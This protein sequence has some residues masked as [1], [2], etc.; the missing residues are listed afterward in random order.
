MRSLKARLYIRVRRTDGH[1]ALLDPAWAKNHTL[2]S[3][4]AW[5]R[6]SPSYIP[7]AST[8]FASVRTVSLS[9]WPWGQTR[10][11]L[12]LPSKTRDTISSQILQDPQ[13]LPLLPIQR[14]VPGKARQADSPGTPSHLEFMGLI[15][16]ALRGVGIVRECCGDRCVP[17]TQL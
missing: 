16:S 8:T 14:L 3:G 9:G 5:S 10:T 7:R 15:T 4:Y 12:S 1:Y 11:P 6:A 2:R 17:P 13:R